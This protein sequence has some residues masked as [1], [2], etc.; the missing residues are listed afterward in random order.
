MDLFSDLPRPAPAAV[1][2]APGALWL[3]HWLALDEQR[4]LVEACRAFMD[5]PAGGY[6]PTV[7]GG[8]RMRVRM[9]CLG[10]HWNAMTYTYE[11]TRG[12]HDQQPVAPL[13]DRWVDLAARLAGQAGFEFRPD[14]CLINWYEAEG[15]MGLH[16]DKDESAGSLA[17]GLPV[18]SLSLGDTARFQFGGTTRREPI[19]SYLLE[20]G[21]AFVFGGPARLRYHGVSR[22]VP[23]SAPEALGLAGRFNLTFRQY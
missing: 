9:T 10:R 19:D 23:G 4:E 22:I 20:S 2:V 16:Q 8:G 11:A 7:R 18:V 17:A 15:R 12:D 14:I 3:R 13:P 21:D 1:H 6:V 5:G